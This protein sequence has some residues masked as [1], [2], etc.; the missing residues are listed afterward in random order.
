MAPTRREELDPE[1]GAPESPGGSVDTDGEATAADEL[2]RCREDVSKDSRRVVDLVSEIHTLLEARGSE[3][4]SDVADV[5]RRLLAT[6]QSLTLALDRLTRACDGL[7]ATSPVAPQPLIGATARFT[8]AD[9]VGRSSALK[10]RLVLAEAAARSDSCVLI[11]GESGTGKELFAQAIHNAGPR[12]RG[13]FVALNC[14]AVP[15]DHLE[16]ELFGYAEAA[17]SGQTARP[18]KLEQARG[19]TLLLDEIGDLPVSLQTRVLRVLNEGVTQ[20]LGNSTDIELDCRVVATTNRDLSIDVAHG[21]FVQELY[22]HLRVIH[23]DL[24]PLRERTD[25]IAALAE[26]FLDLYS[27]RLGKAVRTAAPDVMDALLRYPWPGNVREL[28]Q[29]VE[30]EVNAAAPGQTTVLDIPVAVVQGLGMPRR[31]PTATASVPPVPRAFEPP[32]TAADSGRFAVTATGPVKTMSES[33][34]ELLVAA[35]TAHR[36]NIPSVARALGVSRGTVY[37]KMKKFGLD[38][39]DFRF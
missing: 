31:V 2:A 6:R 39:A 7:V 34:K 15:R 1:R 17:R 13:P 33:E 36:G 3:L 27:E 14:A 21:Q 22:F 18:G 38:P 28:E 35:L 32:M 30:A 37:N 10:R 16:G 29:L 9:I 8:F 11:T 23:I 19:G 26:H 12:A 24:P 25:D 5:H 4:G 20:R